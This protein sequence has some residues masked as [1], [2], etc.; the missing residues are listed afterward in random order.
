MATTISD[1]FVATPSGLDP[2]GMDPLGDADVL[3]EAQ[4]LGVQTDAVRGVAGLLFE[5]R[6][7]LQIRQ[8]DTAVLILRGVRDVTWSAPPRPTELTAWTVDGSTF[9]REAGLLRV[10]MS[11]W[12]SPGADLTVVATSAEFVVGDVKGLEHAPPDYTDGSIDGKIATWNS[13]MTPVM[14]FRVSA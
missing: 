13:V 9:E 1:Y 11:M 5:M 8:G 14:G 6:T 12:P 7:A 3:Q 4:L 2:L 10:S